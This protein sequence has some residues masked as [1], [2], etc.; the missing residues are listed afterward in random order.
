M[1]E[2]LEISPFYTCVPKIISC[3]TVPEI[4]CVT[5]GQTD[6]RTD[7]KSDLQ[8]WVLHLKNKKAIPIDKGSCIVIPDEVFEALV[9]IAVCFAIMMS[10]LI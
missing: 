2:S 8:R 5:D 4:W 6:G 10:K 9:G 3:Y 1:K 7:G